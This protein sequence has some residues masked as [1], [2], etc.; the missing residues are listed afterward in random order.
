MLGWRRAAT[1]AVLVLGSG[2]VAAVVVV[3]AELLGTRHGLAV[4]G[5]GVTA[6]VAVLAIL[7][8]LASRI[9]PHRPAAE[10]G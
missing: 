1:L 3:P 2:A 6:A 9:R 5:A 10:D 4:R 7:A 8:W